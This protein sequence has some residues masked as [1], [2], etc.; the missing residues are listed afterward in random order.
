MIQGSR[1]TPVIPR[2]LLRGRQEGQRLREGDVPG[3][4]AGFEEAAV[5]PDDGGRGCKP[6]RAGDPSKLPRVMRWILL[7]CPL[8]LPSPL[9]KCSPASTLILANETDFRLLAS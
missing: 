3:Q 5:L 7:Y 1:W 4:R 6:R 2:V 9:R 8:P